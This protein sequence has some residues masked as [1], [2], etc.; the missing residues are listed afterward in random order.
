M[1]EINKNN[2]EENNDDNENNDFQ[3]VSR[4]TIPTKTIKN[5]LYNGA[6]KAGN[7][8]KSLIS[9][10]KRIFSNIAKWIV[11]NPKLVL[12][13]A[14]I[15]GLI[16]LICVIV[17]IFTKEETNQT[18]SDS[19]TTVIDS[20]DPDNLTTEQQLASETYEKT[21]SLLDFTVSDIKQMVSEV[22][23]KMIHLHYLAMKNIYIHY[24]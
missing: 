18:I 10:G 9:T 2:I 5:R 20:W 7:L 8:A 15:I 14:I 17:S 24:I 16:I 22:E 12:I 6:K 1:A 13:L 4:S 23:K 21:G 3:Q 19:A 11:T